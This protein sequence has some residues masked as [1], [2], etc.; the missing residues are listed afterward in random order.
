MA[1]QR[2]Q[3]YEGLFL[4]PQSAD[5]GGAA[6][7]VKELLARVDAEI[8]SLSK[9]DER[10]LAYDIAGNKRG[11]YLLAY[12]KAPADR[13]A[14]LERVSNLS[15]RLLRSLVIRAD[16]VSEETMRSTEGQQALDDEIALRRQETDEAGADA[17]DEASE[18]EVAASAE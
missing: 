6:E 15:E 2:I 14:E 17:T 10:R 9:W 4:F 18:E 11:L 3:A 8:L 5:L 16:H 1:E 12:F 13:M 7:H